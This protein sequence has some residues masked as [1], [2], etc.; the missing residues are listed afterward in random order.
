M[1]CPKSHFRNQAAWDTSS[2]PQ[3]IESKGL[4]HRLRL[5][6]HCPRRVSD[7]G[8]LALR[9]AIVRRARNRGQNRGEKT[10]GPS[11]A[12]LGYAK[13]GAFDVGFEVVLAFARVPEVLKRDARRQEAKC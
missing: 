13:G 11:F 7:S 3:P 12:G 10:G 8:T 6:F 9:S 1:F 4:K 2:S 5:L